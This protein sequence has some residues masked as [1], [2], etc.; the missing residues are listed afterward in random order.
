MGQKNYYSILGVKKA[1]TQDDIKKAYRQLAH[2]H[3]PDKTGGDDVRFKEINEAYYVLSDPNRRSKYDQF[4]GG[5]SVAAQGPGAG[6]G[7]AAGFTDGFDGWFSDILEQFFTGAVDEDLLTKKQR[8]RD[9]GVEMTVSLDQAAKGLKEEIPVTRWV[10]CKRCGG[11]GA[12]PGSAMKTCST[13][14]GAGRLHRVEQTFFGTM[15]RLV[16]CPSCQ[17]VGEEP[18]QVCTTC[19]G[20]GRTK[21]QDR[22]TVTLPPGMED[23]ETFAVRGGGDTA[24]TSTGKSGLLYVTV[25]VEQ[26]DT[27]RREGADLWMDEEISFYTLV[28]GGTITVHALNGTEIKVKVPRG[29]P[30]GKIF[31][32][33]GKGMPKRKGTGR[34]DL[35]M[36]IH[37]HV[38]ERATGKTL[39]AL[40]KIAEELE[41]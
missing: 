31:R 38:P 32:V 28:K 12:E 36:T 27:F 14:S 24:I 15:T 25:H 11:Q 13:C 8:G 35:Y 10:R 37:A 33:A 22:I 19:T 26:H 16:I 4:G 17:G 41:M 18:D 1:A 21:Q 30:S 39:E 5:P 3:H 40:K 6:A 2:Q 9:L 23:G 20:A 34:G 7:F 29:T